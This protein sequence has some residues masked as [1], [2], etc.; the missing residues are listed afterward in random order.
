MGRSVAQGA[1]LAGCLGNGRSQQAAD[2]RAQVDSLFE[3]AS[4]FVGLGHARAGGGA[5]AAHA[6]ASYGP[7]YDDGDEDYFVDEEEAARNT[8]DDAFFSGAG[9]AEGEA[10]V[11]RG[12]VNGARRSANGGKGWSIN[13][14]PDSDPT[15]LVHLVRAQSFGL[16]PAQAPSQAASAQDLAGSA[17]SRER[18]LHARA[19]H[20]YWPQLIAAA[21]KRLESSVRVVIAT[22]P[23]RSAAL[24]SKFPALLSQFTTVSICEISSADQIRRTAQALNELPHDVT[25]TTELGA[26]GPTAAAQAAQEQAER[27]RAALAEQEKE[28][29]RALRIAEGTEPSL[30]EEMPAQAAAGEADGRERMDEKD[31]GCT[32]RPGGSAWLQVSDPHTALLSSLLTRSDPSASLLSLLNAASSSAAPQRG[33]G[34]PGTGASDQQ[35]QQVRGREKGEGEIL[36]S[37]ERYA[38]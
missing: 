28:L 6:A 5:R 37:K 1:M 29:L 16:M 18:L 22:N 10:V 25:V 11:V 21:A 38:S 33:E 30:N 35:L 7:A 12:S 17:A 9:A 3:A 32:S 23:S 31:D 24:R 4:N 14:G 2:L 34:E 13:G 15:R 26:G 36:E 20:A 8:E 27:D 19:E